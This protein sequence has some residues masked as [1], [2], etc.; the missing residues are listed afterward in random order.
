MTLDASKVTI[1]ATTTLFRS[2]AIYRT[3]CERDQETTMGTHQELEKLKPLIRWL[4]KTTG[5]Q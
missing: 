2:Q 5:F 3:T 4:K 1:K